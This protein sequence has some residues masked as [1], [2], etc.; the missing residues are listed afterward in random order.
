MTNGNDKMMSN[1][2]DEGEN[3]GDD[4]REPTCA[5]NNVSNILNEIPCNTNSLN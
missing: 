4:R 2:N 5:A 3:D 1:H